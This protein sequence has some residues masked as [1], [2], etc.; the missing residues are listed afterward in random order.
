MLLFLLQLALVRL[1]PATPPAGTGPPETTSPQDDEPEGSR[2]PR[3][4]GLRMGPTCGAASAAP[5]TG[6]QRP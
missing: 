2:K 3:G 4:N 5:N 6:I 1:A